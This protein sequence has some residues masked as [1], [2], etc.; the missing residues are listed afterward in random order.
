MPA[1]TLP[2]S[3]QPLVEYLDGLEERASIDRTRALLERGGVS[4]DDVGEW[5]AFGASNYRRNLVTLGRWYELLVICWKSGQRSPIHDHAASTCGLKV[6]AGVCSET[7]FDRSPCGQMVARSTR[8]LHAGQVCASQDA[9]THQV[10]NLQPP[11][12]DL[13]TLHLYSPPLRAMKQ[14]SITGGSSAEWRPP[15]WEFT[16]GDGI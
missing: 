2:A 14:F 15:V 4:L 5:V 7:V 10:S 11:G 9:D 1:Q 16:G 13:V 6:L 8:E 3:L 12:H